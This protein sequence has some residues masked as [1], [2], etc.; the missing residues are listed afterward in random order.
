MQS[1]DAVIGFVLGN[2]KAEYAKHVLR[3]LRS[4]IIHLETLLRT[5]NYSM[6]CASVPLT[7]NPYRWI[8][9]QPNFINRFLKLPSKMMFFEKIICPLL[10]LGGA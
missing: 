9:P 6:L 5:H 2:P 4:C 3:D 10:E 1:R 8:P 7:I